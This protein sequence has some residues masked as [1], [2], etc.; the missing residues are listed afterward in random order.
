MSDKKF[1]DAVTATVGVDALEKDFHQS[2]VRLG[3]M[4]NA[5]GLR[6]LSEI[7]E[8]VSKAGK[9][10]KLKELCDSLD[11]DTLDMLLYAG[12]TLMTAHLA[13]ETRKL[14]KTKS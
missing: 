7:V 12:T 13:A 8:N 3:K 11:Y 6:G 5:A 2:M 9:H 10:Q 1:V 14:C 4:F